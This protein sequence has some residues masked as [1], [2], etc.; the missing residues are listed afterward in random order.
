M[1][2]LVASDRELP[3]QLKNIVK[4]LAVSSLTEQL[5]KLEKKSNVEVPKRSRPS[6]VDSVDTDSTD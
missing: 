3:E 1:L 2:V 5:V 4:I 6:V